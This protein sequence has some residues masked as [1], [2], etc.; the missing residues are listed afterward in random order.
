MS[1]TNL[2]FDT[3][4]A[5]IARRQLE[6]FVNAHPHI[7]L[8]V[9]TSADGMEIAA[10]P[11]QDSITQRL[12]AMTSSIQALSEAMMREA[13]LSRSRDVIVES[14]TGVIVVVGIAGGGGPHLS[15]AVVVAGEHTLGQ[16]LW[17][18]RQCCSALQRDLAL[19]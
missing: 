6:H 13:G 11:P 17:A 7:S 10:H 18:T 8:A 9:L 3:R 19:T 5:L 1:A 16:V 14:E 15:L 12:A 2:L 4:T